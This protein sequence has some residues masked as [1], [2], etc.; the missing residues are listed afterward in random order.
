M[1]A[2]EPPTKPA[3]DP[4]PASNGAPAA[5]TG[6]DAAEALRRREAE[7]EELRSRNA[8]LEQEVAR[9]RDADTFL[10]IVFQTRGWQALDRY[11]RLRATLRAVQSERL[12][13][14]GVSRA[15]LGPIRIPPA[16]A[17]TASI[18]IPV[19]GHARFTA[20]CLRSVAHNTPAGCYEVVVVDDASP[21]DTPRLLEAADGLTVLHNERNV[22]FVE[23]CNR[24]A[25]AARGEFVLFL[26]ND[27]EPQDGWLDALLDAARSAPDV[28]A[29]GSKLVYP[30]GRL[31]EAGGVVWSDG[32]AMNAGTRDDADDPAFNYRREV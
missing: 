26:N 24:G 20:R 23:S 8:R 4:D 18:V 25:A 15:D 13:R 12:A 9:L 28:G 3:L 10:G 30:D 21:D 29:V 31:Q 27:T 1:S 16:A 19:H 11:Y 6:Q 2:D 7:L 32:S 17:P 14:R 22:G 5:A